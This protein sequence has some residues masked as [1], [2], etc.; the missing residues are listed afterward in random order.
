LSEAVQ[1][2]AQVLELP[3]FKNKIGIIWDWFIYKQKTDE[4]DV[5]YGL[6]L[7]TEISKKLNAATMSQSQNPVDLKVA[8]WGWLK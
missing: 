1:K 4:Q 5:E 2:R 3:L 8:F 6:N 7:T